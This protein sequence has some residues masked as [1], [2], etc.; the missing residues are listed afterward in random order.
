MEPHQVESER[1]YGSEQEEEGWSALWEETEVRCECGAVEAVRWRP[2]RQGDRHVDGVL[3]TEVVECWECG[4]PLDVR[5]QR[6]DREAEYEAR[7]RERQVS[8][9]QPPRRPVVVGSRDV[10]RAARSLG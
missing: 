10:A 4:Q 9:G 5:L 3:R 6:R 2:G 8:A 1:V 7:Q